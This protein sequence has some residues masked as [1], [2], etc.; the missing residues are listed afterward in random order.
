MAT[1]SQ[2]MK[3]PP[4]IPWEDIKVG[5]EYYI[6]TL[7]YYGF[8]CTSTSEKTVKKPRTIR[9]IS[10]NDITCGICDVKTNLTQVMTKFT[11]DYHLL[12]K[13]KKIY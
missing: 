12:T 2:I 1:Y 3:I 4:Q 5:D 10:K 13:R 11:V 8:N 7:I 9:V 6:P